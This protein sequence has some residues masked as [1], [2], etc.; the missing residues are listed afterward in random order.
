MRISLLIFVLCFVSLKTEAQ[1]EVIPKGIIIDS[2]YCNQS[3]EQSYALYL[4]EEYDNKISWPII[5][6]LEPMARGSFA[7]EKFVLAAEEYGY[8]IA[9]SNNSRNGPYQNNYDSFDYL[10]EDVQSKFN[11]NRQRIYVA[12]FS[13]GSRTA[14]AIASQVNFIAGVIGCGAALPTI[15]QGRPN[16]NDD[17]VYVGVVGNKD[18][19]YREMF[20]LKDFLSEINIPNELI[21]FDASHQWPPP[22]VNLKAVEWLHLQSIKLKLIPI[23]S[24][25]LESVKHNRREEALKLENDNNLIEALLVYKG[26][27]DDFKS[28]SNINSFE[29]SYNRI[30]GSKE[31]KSIVKKWNRIRAQELQLQLNYIQAAKELTYGYTNLDSLSDYWSNEIAWLRR[32]EGGEKVFKSQMASRLM[33]MISAMSIEGSSARSQ[34]GDYNGARVLIQLGIKLRSEN[35]YFYYKLAVIECLDGKQD[36]A[37]KALNRAVELGFNNEQWLTSEAFDTIRNT[38]KFN[39]LLEVMQD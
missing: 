9:G 5:I 27:I 22:E 6:L 12:G 25:F 35:F 32:M 19:N 18:M 11:V 30:E 4:P 8:I 20:E 31:Y 39:E 10:L 2:I 1:S 17:F 7:V 3:V 38:E 29:V 14:L 26:L 13:G 16:K 23:D 33:N 28:F 24:S 37:L 34:L 21:I 36:S 15:S